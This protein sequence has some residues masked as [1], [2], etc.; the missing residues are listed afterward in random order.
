MHYAVVGPTWPFRGGIAHFTSLLVRQLRLRHRV[1]LLSFSRQYPRLLFP[2]NVSAD[3]SGQRLAVES[4]RI[5]DGANP[6]T[7]LRAAR[8]LETLRPDALV[9]QWWTP[10]WMPL[11]LLMARAARKRRVPVVYF[12][13][14]ISEPDSRNSEWRFARRTLASGDALI[15]V[16]SSEEAL[17][18]AQFK[19]KYVVRAHMPVFDVTERSGIAR[20]DARARLGLPAH[21]P[22]VLNFGFV[23]PYKGVPLLIDAMRM[24]SPDAHLVIAG[25]FWN[26]EAELRAL[27]AERG[28]D[29][30]VSLHNRYVPNEEIE[31]YFAAADVVALP[32]L[33]GNVSAVLTLAV[34]YGVPVVVSNVGGFTDTVQDGVNGLIVPAGDAAALGAA[35]TR[36]F[37]EDLGRAM[38]AAMARTRD[39]LSWERLTAILDNTALGAGRLV[40]SRGR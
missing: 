34:N 35:L 18:R 33:S 17:L 1:D 8:R 30:R 19:D 32:Y 13:H 22:L 29:G 31:P 3:P 40:A 7:W 14:Q 24:V 9:L 4:E 36:F 5:I 15:A 25:E 26:A 12:C 10:Y 39:A 27:V 23:R 37:A 21:G 2:G 38:R 16:T 28:L 20:S 11:S 6:L